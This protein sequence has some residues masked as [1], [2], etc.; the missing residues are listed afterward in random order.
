MKLTAM[1]KLALFLVAL[2]V[3]FGGYKAFE[4]SRV[5]GAVSNSAV[6]GSTRRAT[7]GAS[8]ASSP[9]TNSTA[10]ADAGAPVAANEIVLLTNPGKRGWLDEQIDKFNRQSDVKI[11]ARS[12]PTREAM[13]AMLGQNVRPALWS[14]SSVIWADRLAQVKG[15][16][17]VDTGDVSSYRSVLR[18]PL[19]FLTTA[20]KARFL[21]PLLSGQN[22]WTNIEA[23]STGAKKA[24]WGQFKWAHADPIQS[25]SGMLTLAL[26]LADYATRTG[27]SAAIEKLPDNPT[28]F[29]YFS[30]LEKSASY[31]SAVKKG[32][33]ALLKSFAQDPTRYDFITAYEAQALGAVADNP[34]LA[35]IYPSPTVNAE[36]AVAF[37]DW[38]DASAEQKAAAQGF[39]KFVSGAESAQDGVKEFYRPVRGAS[40]NAQLAKYS[41]QGFQVNYSSIELPPYIAL[42]NL[43][44]RWSKQIAG[45]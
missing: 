19:V 39:L 17:V 31:D 12:L 36:S 11:K 15:N 22:G 6:P 8:N 32:S 41:A 30:R 16:T 3:A 20:E 38:G 43:A 37:L 13:H 14:P 35:V 7:T 28:F 5:G 42:N 10:Q 24:P 29:A 44:A 4:K 25:N 2:G 23:L 34:E 40:L 1:G 26:V 33:T 45:K 27:Q 21:R 18:S 9:D